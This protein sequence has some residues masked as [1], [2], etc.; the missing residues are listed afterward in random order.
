MHNIAITGAH[1]FTGKNFT[2]LATAAGYTIIP[3]ESNL[4][5]KQG[6]SAELA[7]IDCD[8]IVHLAAISAVTHS[9]LLAFYEVNVL[10]TLNLLNAVSSKKSNAKKIL[11]ASSANIYGNSAQSPIK[12]SNTAAPVNHYAMSKLSM[13]H[14]IAAEFSELPVVTVRPFNYTGR[15][16]D[17]RFVVPK[18]VNHFKRKSATIELG[19]MGVEREYND[20]R[21]I[22]KIYLRL[23]EKGISGETYNVCSGHTHTLQNVIETLGRL[24]NHTIEVSVNPAFIR[25]QEV[26]KL[27]GCP[28]KLN[29][30]IGEIKHHNLEDTL[31]WMLE[32]K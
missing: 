26:K 7:T 31:K 17:D 29:A 18:I 15:D 23:L 4:T 21:S 16:H 22:C 25:A 19:N 5:N 20:V 10:G 24:T 30:C 11:I 13:E 32:A 14:M 3:V 6:L 12:E 1:G 9:E 8:Y 28:S 2:R 27:C